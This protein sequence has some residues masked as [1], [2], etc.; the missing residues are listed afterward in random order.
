MKEER[1]DIVL[2]QKLPWITFANGYM[3]QITNMV[4]NRDSLGRTTTKLTLRPMEELIKRYNI[5]T[6]DLDENNQ[7]NVEYPIDS[8]ILLSS[9]PAWTTYLCTLDFEG[10]ECEGTIKLGSKNLNTLQSL[11]DVIK[12]HKAENAY[13]K[14]KL[15]LAETN[16][17]QYIKEYITSL[18][19]SASQFSGMGTTSIEGGITQ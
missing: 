3:A 16:M 10:K 5:S 19:T 8:I 15:I 1:R 11:R 12:L 2:E 14:E 17:A 6:E 13:L 18:K 7:L 4:E 9:D